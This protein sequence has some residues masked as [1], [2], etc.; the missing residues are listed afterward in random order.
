M[1][2]IYRIYPAVGI[3]RIGNS[4]TGNFL[5]PE[6][7]GIV[8]EGPYRDSSSPGKI[9]PQAVRF[10]IDKFIRDEFGKERLDS[11]IVLNAKTRIT[12]SVHLANSKAAGGN[13]PLPEARPLLP[14]TPD[15]TE[16]GCSW[17]PH[18]NQY[19]EKTRRLAP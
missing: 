18:Y 8:P 4:E 3:A 10:R 14:E 12:W 15:T 19:P 17:M 6:S 13:F 7:P 1:K 16:R 2:T 9:K 11:E 5:G